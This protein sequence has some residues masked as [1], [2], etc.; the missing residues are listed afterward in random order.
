MTVRLRGHH[1]LCMLTYKGEGY[2]PAFIANFDS[3]IAR[4]AQG[5]AVEL[6]KGADDICTC[7]LAEKADA[8]CLNESVSLRDEL[9]LAQIENEA[10]SLG[11]KFTLDAKKLSSL[12][13]A[14]A[15][16][17][18]RAACDGCEWHALCTAIADNGFKNARLKI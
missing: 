13:A 12:R 6:V 4:V 9:A 8:H 11:K 2:S 16:K 5:E 1:L 18:I 17:R 10:F 7:L 3:I 15:Q 14:F